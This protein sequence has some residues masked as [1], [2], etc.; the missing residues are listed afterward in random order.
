MQQ[1]WK[2]TLGAKQAK[3][4]ANVKSAWNFTSTYSHISTSYAH[5]EVYFYNHH[6][7]TDL[8]KICFEILCAIYWK[9]TCKILIILAFLTLNLACGITSL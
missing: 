7:L 4:N 8:Q 6:H 5:A 1:L 2:L 3:P 9:D